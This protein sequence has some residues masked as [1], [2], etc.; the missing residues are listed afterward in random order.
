M[1]RCLG[2]AGDTWIGC[3]RTTASPSGIDEYVFYSDG[4]WSWAIPY[5]AGLY[6]LAVQVDPTIT[7]D[8]FW[9]LAMETADTIELEHDGEVI[10]FGPIA[11]PGALIEALQK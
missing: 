7:P 4:G 5:I 8:Q 2:D 10:P 11:N 1:W 9:S 3:T 6:A